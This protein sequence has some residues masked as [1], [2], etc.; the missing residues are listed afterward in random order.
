MSLN[1]SEKQQLV[2]KWDGEPEE[3]A[4]YMTDIQAHCIGLGHHY[5]DV[6][7]KQGDYSTCDYKQDHKM[8]TDTSKHTTIDIYHKAARKIYSVIIKSLG[9]KPKIELLN[10]GVTIGDGPSAFKRLQEVYQ[11]TGKANLR[12]LFKELI[13]INHDETGSYQQYVFRFRNL[14]DA[15]RLHPKMKNASI[16]DALLSAIF[17]NGLSDM[18]D[19]IV[20][21]LDDDP[22]DPALEDIISRVDNFSQKVQSERTSDTAK[23]LAVCHNWSRYGKCKFGNSCKYDHHPLDAHQS[24]VRKDGK[25]DIGDTDTINRITRQVTEAVLSQLSQ[26]NN[27]KAPMSWKLPRLDRKNL[28]HNERISEAKGPSGKCYAVFQGKN[29]F[30]GVIQRY[31]EAE[32]LVKKGGKFRPGV[33]FRKCSSEEEAANLIRSWEAEAESSDAA[34]ITHPPGLALH[35]AEGERN[36]ILDSGAY[37][38]Y[39]PAELSSSYNNVRRAQGSV[40]DA[41]GRVRNFFSQ[42]DNSRF[43]G[44]KFVPGFRHK[45]A[46]IGRIVDGPSENAVLFRRNDCLEGKFTI[47]NARV[48]GKRD[49]STGLWIATDSA[50]KANLTN[51]ALV[52]DNRPNNLANLWHARCGHRQIKDIIR[53]I[54][55]GEL[56]IPGQ[57]TDSLRDAARNMVPCK[58][59][60]EAKSFRKPFHRNSN[61]IPASVPYQRLRLDI[62]GPISPATRNG[63]RYFL[64]IVDEFTTFSWVFFLRQRSDASVAFTKFLQDIGI[65]KVRE[66]KSIRTDGA[67]ELSQGAFRRICLQHDIRME[68]SS[69]YQSTGMNNVAE[70]CIR[71]LTEMARSM[72]CHANARQCDWDEAI[73]H[74][75]WLR[76]RLPNSS[77][78]PPLIRLRGDGSS[79]DFR[80]LRTWYS[81]VFCRDPKIPRGQKFRPIAHLGTFLGYDDNTLGFRVRLPTGKIVIRRDVYFME[82]LERAKHLAG[83]KGLDPLYNEHPSAPF[84][85]SFYS[86]PNDD[87]IPNSDHTEPGV[88]C[89]HQAPVRSSSRPR[90]PRVPHNVGGSQ[91]EILQEIQER[92]LPINPAAIAM[93]Y[94]ALAVRG[95]QY[96]EDA[97]ARHYT[98]RSYYD[99]VSCTDSAEWIESIQEEYANMMEH[100]VFEIVPAPEHIS[101][102]VR[103]KLIFKC[104][105]DENG[106]LIKRKTRLCMKGFTQKYGVDYDE[107]FSPVVRPSS[108]RSFLV[109]A[110]RLGLDVHQFDISAA[111]LHAKFEE[112]Y[113][114][115]MHPPPGLNVPPGHILR[116]NRALY[117]GKQSGRLFNTL[118]SKYLIERLGF[119][120]SIL[121]PCVFILQKGKDVAIL[122]IHVDDGLLA[123]N[124][125]R[126]RNEIMQKLSSRFKIGASNPLRYYVGLEINIL[127]NR[128]QV[129]CQRKIL[130]LADR[131]RL[132]DCNPVN[133]PCSP[134]VRLQSRKDNEPKLDTGKYP[135]SSL[136]GGL[137]FIANH[138]RPDIAYAVSQLSR[139]MHD[140]TP[141]HWKAALRV[142]AYLRTTVDICLE[143]KRGSDGKCTVSGICDSDFAGDETRRSCTGYLSFVDGN[144]VNWKSHLQSVIALSTLE[145][146]L[147][148][149]VENSQD[150]TYITNLL[151]E[152]K[153]PFPCDPIIHLRSDNQPAIHVCKNPAYHGR[154]KHIDVKQHYLRLLYQ[155]GA[156]EINSIASADNPADILT[157]PMPTP[158]FVR[159]RDKLMGRVVRMRGA[160]EK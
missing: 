87:T 82:D 125:V 154:A 72:I 147:Y 59:C 146:E 38:H 55:S 3:F 19:P 81:P 97:T 40:S 33:K 49:S 104:K 121:D 15:I 26:N 86:I 136:V 111:F 158:S 108:L 101:N 144:L 124:S 5:L 71:D 8:P 56:H 6:L 100:E 152:M 134:G 70:K 65:P 155:R 35:S 153:L 85:R 58:G 37:D 148:A 128:L 63:K 106:H 20:T 94:N 23:A 61:G 74:A 130:D 30:S 131:F 64:V 159:L 89:K 16:P 90:A 143:F 46:S 41:N 47:E 10:A 60:G 66:I 31:E 98:P 88:D 7:L 83:D 22:K 28:A 43:T 73:H 21:I 138:A 115:F 141:A 75:N 68:Q 12:R 69:P 53:G 132:S 17:T 114:I 29:N 9:K 45:L 80:Y 120:Q 123:T 118:F 105:Y 99:A 160:V 109:I 25:Q 103:P 122:A 14:I 44:V 135:Y 92:K 1:S 142:L 96:N 156:A 110:A 91:A 54:Q 133:N 51:S 137:L 157:K 77:G 126:F 32:P 119:R 2:S 57:S 129:T 139:F 24:R 145:S 113:K 93:S 151:Q 78:S 102:V 11:N 52:S 149:L 27:K 140:P 4:L 62:C 150:A 13:L 76:C 127:D 48:I 18:Y 36:E 112:K 34:L 50:G 39:A 116:L 117:G 79:V 107:T 42:G 67:K 84:H 95:V